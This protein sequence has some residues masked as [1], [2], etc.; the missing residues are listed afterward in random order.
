MQIAP[1]PLNAVEVAKHRLEQFIEEFTTVSLPH[2]EQAWGFLTYLLKQAKKYKL[3]E[4]VNYSDYR[5]DEEEADK[6]VTKY[7]SPFG[8]HGNKENKP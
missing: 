3:P 5:K 8:Y 4:S 2:R 1:P 7:L 6:N